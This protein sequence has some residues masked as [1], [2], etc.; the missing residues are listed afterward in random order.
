[1]YFACCDNFYYFIHDND[2]IIIRFKRSIELKFASLQLLQ[3]NIKQHSSGNA[4][5]I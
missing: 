3:T 4:G 5:N 1:M 2:N